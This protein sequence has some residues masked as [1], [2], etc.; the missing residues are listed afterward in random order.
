VELHAGRLKKGMERMAEYITAGQ[1]QL[2]ASDIYNIDS[3]E[4]LGGKFDVIVMKDAI[5]HIVD[6]KRLIE[7]LKAFLNPGGVV[8]FGFPPWQ[9][10]FG[11]HQQMCRSKWLSHLPY[12]HLLPMPVYQWLTRRESKELIEIKQTGISIERFE[13]I[14]KETNY[15]IVAELYFLINPIYQYKFNIK[16]RKQGKIISSI[17]FLRDFLTTTVFYLIQ[18]K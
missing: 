8:F 5:E 10:P 14:I 9:M 15:R 2:I 6:Q 12:F 13:K 7:R 11:G 17:P 4:V 3:E 18:I 16:A 1:L